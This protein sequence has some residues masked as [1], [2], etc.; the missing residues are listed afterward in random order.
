MNGSKSRSKKWNPQYLYTT[1]SSL[2]TLSTFKVPTI[3]FNHYNICKIG[4]DQIEWIPQF[5]VHKNTLAL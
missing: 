4:T 2:S 5:Q 1:S 3:I